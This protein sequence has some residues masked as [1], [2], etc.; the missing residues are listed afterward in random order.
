MEAYLR[1]LYY[2]VDSPVAFTSEKNLWEQIKIDHKK[3][4]RLDLR[5][6][7]DEQYTYTL[8]KSYNKPKSYN[9]TTAQA[10]DQQ[11]QADLVNMT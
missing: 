4:T 5:K 2:D 6:W 1:H 3:I 11:W 8:H 10:V 7:L 9:K